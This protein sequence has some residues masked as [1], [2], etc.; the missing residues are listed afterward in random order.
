MNLF[1][2]LIIMSESINTWLEVN[3]YES[4]IKSFE[5]TLKDSLDKWLISKELANELME[6][7]KSDKQ[8]I[9]EDSRIAINISNCSEKEINSIIEAI[10]ILEK[11]NKSDTFTSKSFWSFIPSL[12]AFNSWKEF[13]RNLLSNISDETIDKIKDISLKQ[14]KLSIFIMASWS[15]YAAQSI[16][17]RLNN[18]NWEKLENLD[19]LNQNK[20]DDSELPRTIMF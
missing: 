1:F 15:W 10:N 3:S 9:L 8:S 18:V 19:N 11:D 12:I 17:N 14:L 13:G 6:R 20:A 5:D 7:Y 4:E 16:K 2:N